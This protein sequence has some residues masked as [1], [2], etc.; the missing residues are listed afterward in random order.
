VGLAAGPE[1]LIA[2]RVRGR[3]SHPAAPVAAVALAG[4]AYLLVR[5]ATADMA[6]HAYREWL[7]STEGLTIWN[8]QWYGGH[9][10]LGYSL[11]FAPLAAWPG[12]A[13]AGALAAVAA[14]AAFVPLA[15]AA[16]P[17]P[18]VA[19]AAAWLWAAG[20]ASNLV[21]GR[22]P[23]TLGIA[24]GV[25]AWLAAGRARARPGAPSR[26]VAPSRA[27][28]AAAGVLSTA[29]VLTSPV[30]GAFLILAAAALAAGGRAEWPRAAAL[31]LP[32]A[33]GGVALALLFPE[34]GNDRFVATAFWPMAIVSAAG[35]A[36]L[37]PHSR[38]L[39][40]GGL[41]YLA[42][43]AAAFAVPN[44]LGQNAMR[45]GL[46][47]GPVLLVLAPRRG[48]PRAAL[49]LV[50]AAFAYLQWL[51]AV[52]AVVEAHGDP[53]TR[54]EFY[55]EPKA[56]L[57]RTIRPGER[58]E[59]VFTRNH[60]EVAHLAPS[61][62]LARG[63]ERQLDQKTNPLFYD[64]TLS[65]GRYHR[66]LRENGVRFVALA[67]VPLDYSAVAEAELL[68][69]GAPFLTP[70][71]RAGDWR[72][73]EV[74]DPGPPAS[75]GGRLLA[76]GPDEFTVSTEG[77]TVV[78][79]RYTRWWRSAGACL[80]EAPGGWTRVVPAGPGPVRVQARLSGPA[81]PDGGCAQ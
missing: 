44:P 45:L 36:L 66:W 26:P 16:A 39:R 23:F 79:Q 64:G 47:L 42:L 48:A 18:G 25:L 1:Q 69:R 2:H 77:P 12:P 28:L 67:D 21:I 35:V 49:A 63:W 71:L 33:A 78:R 5:P 27:R 56:L 68:E 8:A 41:A 4:L 62:P 74:D 7:F 54:A 38:S 37:T 55:A 13:W 40:A 15:R 29:C 10:V 70:V 6:A 53:S 24:F 19:A 73:W 30:A 65:P 11:L 32:T 58:V 61:V 43:L 72:V 46:L 52:R 22:M 50:L 14:T 57:E 20:V 34:G 60:W 31:A 76:A 80:S 81:P 51:P 75:G 17:T 59:V 9:H 3:A